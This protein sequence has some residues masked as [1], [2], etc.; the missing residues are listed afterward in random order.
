M[1]SAAIILEVSTC[2][3]IFTLGPIGTGL[4]HGWGHVIFG[5]NQL[6]VATYQK[7]RIMH[8]NCNTITKL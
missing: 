8:H 6:M 4:I 3:T 5:K 1:N 2:S 7:S